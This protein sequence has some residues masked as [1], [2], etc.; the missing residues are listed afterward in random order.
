MESP[1]AAQCSAAGRSP[2]PT[3]PRQMRLQRTGPRWF[4]AHGIARNVLPC[5]GAVTPART[6]IGHFGPRLIVTVGAVAEL[7]V[8]NHRRRTVEQAPRR[9]LHRRRLTSPGLVGSSLLRLGGKREEHPHQQT[10]EGK[11]GAAT[12]YR[13]QPHRTL[14]VV[15][16]LADVVH[17]IESHLGWPARF[18]S[19]NGMKTEPAEGL[20]RPSP[21][22]AVQLELAAATDHSH[23]ISRS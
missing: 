18:S 5:S 22:R 2:E 1:V 21:R 11:P 12:S 7:L 10:A 23:R 17:R 8:R 4:A 15:R 20:P 19:K 16:L 9:P 6:D 13:L 3:A 14:L